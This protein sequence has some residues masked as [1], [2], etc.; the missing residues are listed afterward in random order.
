MLNKIARSVRAFARGLQRISDVPLAPAAPETPTVGL[1]LG[2][3]FA[4]GL[5]HIGILKVLEEEGIPVNFIAGTSVGSVI[6]AAYCSGI[7][8]RELEEIAAQVRFKDFARWT[9]SRYGFASNDRMARFLNK[10]L[11]CR[12]FEELK[13]PLAVAATDFTSG[14]GVVFRSGNLVD[15]VRASCA[16]PGMFLPVNINGRLLV[17]GMLAHAVPT[18]PLREMGAQRVIAGYLSAHWVNGDGP[19]HVFDVIGQ[20]FSIAQSRMCGLWE[21]AAD[22]IVQ[23]D[24]RGFSYDGFDRATELIRAGEQAARAALPAI[25]QW[26]PRPETAAL[27]TQVKAPSPA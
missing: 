5:A 3:G 15:A 20:C 21:A 24:V 10:M 6:G 26:F 4:R 11:R 25:Q 12:T 16:Y 22:V 17:D 14:E 9:L 7:S 19:R 23:P 27:A 18:V 8:A 2:G 13:I 1:A